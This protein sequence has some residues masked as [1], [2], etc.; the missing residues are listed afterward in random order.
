MGANGARIKV[1]RKESLHV[2]RILKFESSKMQIS[3]F[4]VRY[5]NYVTAVSG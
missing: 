5:F 1:A 4:F 3:V 2:K